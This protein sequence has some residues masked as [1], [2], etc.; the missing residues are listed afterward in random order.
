MILPTE[1]YLAAA[2]GAEGRSHR[3]A[4][5]EKVNVK[6]ESS[7][8]HTNHLQSHLGQSVSVLCAEGG[9]CTETLSLIPVVRIHLPLYL[10]HS[11]PFC[12]SPAWDEGSSSAVHSLELMLRLT[13][14]GGDRALILHH[15]AVGLVISTS[16]EWA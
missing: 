9:H 11:G 16:A 2:S 10:V 15:P 14:K 5:T 6:L 13:P 3:Q 1:S 8:S 7:S 4:F 12:L